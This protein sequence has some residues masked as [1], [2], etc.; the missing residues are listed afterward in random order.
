M[1][2]KIKKYIRENKEKIQAGLFSL[3]WTVV[4]V[5]ATFALSFKESLQC[6]SK[7]S[8]MQFV[9]D[10]DKF[11]L[12]VLLFL[13]LHLC[14]FVYSIQRCQ[15]KVSAKFARWNATFIAMLL[16]LIAGL[17]FY[18]LSSPI[19]GGY[20]FFAMLLILGLKFTCVYFTNNN[21]AQ[22]NERIELMAVSTK[23]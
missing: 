19:D 7:G 9:N 14:E 18:N 4:L 21:I 11:I 5:M 20:F 16:C 3:I 1:N 13:I 17:F 23:E 10:S 12:P 2:C 22:K 6:D 8:F 15:E